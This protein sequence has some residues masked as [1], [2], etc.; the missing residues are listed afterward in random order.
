MTFFY[1]LALWLAGLGFGAD[2]R[3]APSRQAPVLPIFAAA[4]LDVR[5]AAIP[6]APAG[7][8]DLRAGLIPVPRVTAYSEGAALLGDVPLAAPG[9]DPG[10]VAL[11]ALRGSAVVQ[12][13]SRPGVDPAPAAEG[14]FDGASTKVSLLDGPLEAIDARVDLIKNA[15]TSV[16]AAYYRFRMDAAGLTKLYLLREA[17]R[18]GRDV[19]LVLD[20]WGSGIT[21]PMLKHLIEEGVQI[22]FYHPLR[23]DHPSWAW[24][25]SHD[26][27][28]IVDGEAAILGDRNMGNHYFGMGQAPWTSREARVDGEVAAQAQAYAQQMWDGGEVEAPRGLERISAER[29]DEAKRRLDGVE[30]YFARRALRRPLPRPWLSRERLVPGAR[31]SRNPLKARRALAG[32]TG[33]DLLKM[34]RGANDTIVIENSYVILP[35][36]LKSELERAI[37]RGVRVVLLTN[38]PATNNLFSARTA[39]EADLPMLIRMGME[40]WEFQGPGTLHAKGMVVDGRVVYLGSFNLD[41]RSLRLNTETGVVG[42]DPGLAR[43]LLFQIRQTQENSILVGFGRRMLIPRRMIPILGR[44]WALWRSLLLV[45]LR[46]QV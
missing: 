36:I 28:V 21:K 3:L 13:L 30:D 14:F 4:P 26:K 5:D 46:D 40:L 6:S 22:R 16:F 37:K 11:R 32:G 19:K 25:R 9:A 15:K 23:I 2:T 42:E 7:L 45:F 12:A 41:P 20:P 18:R 27:W 33:R 24:R 10:G 38:S 29:T 39:Y 35:S 31:F 43:D 8:R 34:I 44:L 1:L 17:A